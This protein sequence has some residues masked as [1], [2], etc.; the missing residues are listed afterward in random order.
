ML[1]IARTLMGNP[2]LL[3]LDEPSEG[4]APLIVLALRDAVKEIKRQGLS[5]LLSEQNVRF[6]MKVSDHAYVID[7]GRIMFQGTITGEGM[8]QE[9]QTMFTD[10]WVVGYGTRLKTFSGAK[11]TGNS[12]KWRDFW[13]KDKGAHSYYFIGKDNIPFHTLIWPA[14]LMGYA[15]GNLNLPYDIPAN[16]FLTI[17]GRKLS[18]SQTGQCGERHR[19]QEC[20]H[21]PG[22][23]AGGRE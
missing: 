8:S 4:L 9:I 1:T 5:I 11:S 14:M 18:T 23:L 21:D 13:E 6:S 12:E 2:Q 15:D 17:E 22:R 20:A 10:S 16:E 19:G 7:G 3:L